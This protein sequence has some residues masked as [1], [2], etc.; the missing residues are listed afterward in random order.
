MRVWELSG[1]FGLD[2]LRLAERPRPEPGPGQALVRLTAASLNFRDL[3]LVLGTYNPKE[4][5]P[6][7]PLADGAGVVEAVGAGVTRVRPGDRVVANFFQGWIGGEPSAEKFATSMGGFG[8]DGVAMEYR[9]FDE[10]GLVPIP[11]SLSDEAAAALPCAGLTAWSAVVTLGRVAPGDM[12]L[13]Q[14]TGGVSLFALQFARLA[15]ASV[16]V[17]S[18]SDEKLERA[19]SLGA[20][21]GINYRRE[22]DWGR[23]ARVLTGGRGV[24][25]VIEVGG[26]GTLA[27]SVRA[28]RVGGRIALIGVLAGARHELNLPLIVMQQIR[29]EGV[30]VGSR[31]G[32]EAMLRAIAAAKLQ[33][34]IDRTFA[35]DDAPAAFRH[36]QAGA[37][38]GKICLRF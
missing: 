36:M 12:V 29:L 11:P 24:D 7:V 16:I 38:F 18:S 6:I 21:H 34:V 2:N 19:R 23:A 30:T 3:L 14:G 35:F 27:Q 33:P 9:L 17:T 20:D 26:A 32:F 37:H 25:H 1:G 10:Q 8:V 13:V 4:R 31:E 28:T 15:G 5:L 22:P